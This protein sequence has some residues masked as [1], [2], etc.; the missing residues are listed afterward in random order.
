M[1]KS[2]A[3]KQ[4]TKKQTAKKQVVRKLHE[5]SYEPKPRTESS[6]TKPKK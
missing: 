5:A 2:G 1:S 4:T 3:K 6:G